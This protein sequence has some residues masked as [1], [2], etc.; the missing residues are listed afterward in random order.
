MSAHVGEGFTATLHHVGESA[1]VVSEVGVGGDG[2]RVPR[3]QEDVTGGVPGPG[4]LI[5]ME[6][7]DE[8]SPRPDCVPGHDPVVQVHHVH[9]PRID[10]HRQSGLGQ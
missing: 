2:G 8:D 3:P 4:D 10:D 1:L 9:Q 7:R 5:L 6:D